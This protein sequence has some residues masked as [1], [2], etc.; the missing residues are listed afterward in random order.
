M[1]HSLGRR[2]PG[3]SF[4]LGVTGMRGQSPMTLES[5][6]SIDG[7]PFAYDGLAEADDFGMKLEN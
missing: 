2:N 3:A 6:M 4:S 5:R 1:K 7:A